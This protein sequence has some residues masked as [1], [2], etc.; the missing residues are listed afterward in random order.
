MILIFSP[1]L[2]NKL[3]IGKDLIQNEM[4]QMKKKKSYLCYALM[5]LYHQLKV[6]L[7]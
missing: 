5:S 4:N 6:T 2:V 7:H 3:E 1:V